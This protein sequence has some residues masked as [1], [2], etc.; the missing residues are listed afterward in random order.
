MT[1]D[2]CV[3]LWYCAGIQYTV[4]IQKILYEYDYHIIDI[5]IV[6]VIVTV[7]IRHM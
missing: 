3:C 5:V 4:H 7:V 1:C 2:V 6:T